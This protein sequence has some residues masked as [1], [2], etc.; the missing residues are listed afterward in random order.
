MISDWRLQIEEQI[1]FLLRGTEL[2]NLKSA[3]LNLK[4]PGPLDPNSLLVAMMFTG[5]PGGVYGVRVSCYNDCTDNCRRS[6]S[7]PGL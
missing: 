3:F 5:Y 7:Y 2:F 1:H 6:G 4:S